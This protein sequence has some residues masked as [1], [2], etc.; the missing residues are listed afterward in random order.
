MLKISDLGSAKI[1]DPNGK[2]TS[3]VVTQYYR[4][5]ELIFSHSNYTTAIDIWGK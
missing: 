3:Y 2:N 1:L 4:A 5:P